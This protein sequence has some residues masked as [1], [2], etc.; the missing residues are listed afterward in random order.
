MSR[1]WG[2]YR[3]MVEHRSNT[4]LVVTAKNLS[5]DYKDCIQPLQVS[6]N[7]WEGG[8]TVT[9]DALK[10]PKAHFQVIGHKWRDN[11]WTYQR[12]SLNP[13]ITI[14]GVDDIRHEINY[15]EHDEAVRAVSLWQAPDGNMR[16]QIEVLTST[17]DQWSTTLAASRLPCHLAS[18]QLSRCIWSAITY[19]LAAT[20]ISE[21]QCNKIARTLYTNSIPIAGISK[22]FPKEVRYVPLDFF[23]LGFKN[24]MD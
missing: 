3:P 21:N 2:S 15:L 11:R 18:I 19:P 13:I 12:A 22:S 7:I 23:G 9:G 17:A 4:D 1:K 20:S 14:R 8:L 5:T 10:P 6:V 24:R 16:K